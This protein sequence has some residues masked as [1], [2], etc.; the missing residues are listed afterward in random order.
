MIYVALI[1]ALGVG[2]IAL[3]ANLPVHPAI[4]FI[5]G[6]A[7][8]YGISK[9][10]AW[11]LKIKDDFGLLMIR[12]QTGI[13]L[14]NRLAKYEEFWKVF[15]DLGLVIAYGVASF[16]MIKRPL[17]EKTALFFIGLLT[18]SLLAFGVL[19]YILPFMT[20]V[21]GT[22]G[23]AAKVPVAK[24]YAYAA[25][26]MLYV[27][28]FALSALAS[29]VLYALMILSALVGTYLFGTGEISKIAPGVTLTLPGVTIPFA[30]GVVALAIILAVH[31]FAH[32]VLSRIARVR[33]ISSGVVLLGVVPIGAFVEPDEQMLNK[34]E[35][36][37]QTR[38]LVAG[39]AANFF[40]AL[41]IFLAFGLFAMATIQYNIGESIFTGV[42]AN[43]LLSFVYT[44]LGLAFALNFAIGMVNLLPLP[45]FDGYRLAELNLG[46]KKLVSAV[47]WIA[48]LAFAVN[49]LPWLFRK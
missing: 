47:S 17:K 1:F 4:K 24:D 16:F 8:M 27:G 42:Y 28:G 31:E 26:A 22:S 29:L 2:L 30:E 35:G 15:A 9:L 6:I 48:I 39:S 49:F 44:T 23:I 32:A 12:S 38:V 13:N 3:I 14:I 37:K 41:I 36:V 7:A 34:I 10:L 19:P 25:V 43:P 40:A 20:T 33:I 46:N 21:L 18:L 11:K 45:F 5:A